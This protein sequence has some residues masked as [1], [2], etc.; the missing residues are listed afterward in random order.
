M[1]EMKS[2]KSAEF[3]LVKRS[4]EIDFIDITEDVI[5][6]TEINEMKSGKLHRLT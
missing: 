4:T 3:N 5:L 2:I 6:K 1:N